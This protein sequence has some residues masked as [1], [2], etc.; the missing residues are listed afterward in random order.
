ML[1]HRKKLIAGICI[2]LTVILVLGVAVIR[3]FTAKHRAVRHF[4]RN[5][6][7]IVLVGDFLAGSEY[8]EISISPDIGSRMIFV[9]RPGTSRVPID[10]DGVEE[11]VARLQRRGYRSIGKN[12][13]VIV[14][15]RGV[16]IFDITRG[17]AYSIDGSA[18]DDHSIAFLTRIEPLAEDNWFF[19]EADYNEYRTRNRAP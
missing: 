1:K 10:N 8:D 13:G 3:P 9:N 11:A 15:G 19:Y 12:D 2:A 17:V 7:S 6:E 4:E 18:P 16:F 14:F 5:R